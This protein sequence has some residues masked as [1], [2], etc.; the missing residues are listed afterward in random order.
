M[1]KTLSKYNLVWDCLG[2]FGST[3]CGFGVCSLVRLMV[4]ISLGKIHYSRDLAMLGIIIHIQS[5]IDVLREAS[6]LME[7]LDGLHFGHPRSYALVT[8]FDA[9]LRTRYILRRGSFCS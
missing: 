4:I 9:L 5:T 6:N 2:L 3:G 8:T 7:R 1:K